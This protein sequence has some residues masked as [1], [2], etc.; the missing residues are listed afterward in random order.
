MTN[1]PVTEEAVRVAKAICTA[2]GE[3]H[4]EDNGFP[5]WRKYLPDARAAIAAL[6]SPPV[7]SEGWQPIETAPK[8]RAAKLFID[9]KGDPRVGRWNMSGFYWQDLHSCEPMPTPQIWLPIPDWQPL[10]EPPLAMS[11]KSEATQG[12]VG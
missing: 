10:P 11:V 9:C 3:A 5:E 2:N 12:G 1:P 7:V 8:D 6:K 4:F